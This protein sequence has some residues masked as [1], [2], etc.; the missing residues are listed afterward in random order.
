[1]INENEARKIL[2]KNVPGAKIIGSHETPDDYLFLAPFDDPIEG[3]LLP[4]FKV[5]KRS[6]SFSDFSPLDYENSREIIDI[7]NV[8]D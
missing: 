6:G 3:R 7:L 4:F 5:G 1:M 2:I 8:R